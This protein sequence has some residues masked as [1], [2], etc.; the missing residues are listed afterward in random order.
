MRLIFIQEGVMQGKIMLHA[1]PALFYF[2]SLSWYEIL[3]NFNHHFVFFHIFKRIIKAKY[4]TTSIKGR[5]H[6]PFLPL[7]L[8]EF[9][10]TMIKVWNKGKAHCSIYERRKTPHFHF[11]LIYKLLWTLKTFLNNPSPASF[12]DR[13]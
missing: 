10:V 12:N 7:L 8:Q 5:E 1:V 3:L 11:F 2:L 6:E 13:D 4:H 9:R